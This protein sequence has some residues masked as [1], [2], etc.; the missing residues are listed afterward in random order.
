MAKQVVPLSPE[1]VTAYG[2]ASRAISGLNEGNRFAFAD[3][4]SKAWETKDTS[5]IAAPQRAAQAYQTVNVELLG[6]LDKATKSLANMMSLDEKDIPEP[7]KDHIKA[8]KEKLTQ[9]GVNLGNPAALERA[10]KSNLTDGQV[11]PVT[12]AL[13]S[14]TEKVGIRP[15]QNGK[16]VAATSENPGS[17]NAWSKVAAPN[18]NDRFE[19]TIFDIADAHVQARAKGAPDRSRA[20]GPAQ[21][22]IHPH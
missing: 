20:P 10:I 7:V 22:A 12:R 14:I 13:A 1:W 8:A 6:G 11:G 9:S 2:R 3:I 19:K 17:Y 21:P 18:G 4:L 16:P 5:V 15:D